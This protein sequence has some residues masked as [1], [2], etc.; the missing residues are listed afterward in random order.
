MR[1]CTSSFVYEFDFLVVID[2]DVEQ[3]KNIGQ[4][5]K[6]RL[7]FQQGFIDKDDLSVPY[8]MR[9][10]LQFGK[11]FLAI[12]YADFSV[13]QH[14]ESIVTSWR[15]GLPEKKIGKVYQFIMRNEGQFTD[16]VSTLS[17]ISSYVG[18][19]IYIMNSGVVG[20]HQ[21]AAIAL[22]LALASGLRSVTGIA[23]EMVF[24]TLKQF[25]PGPTIVLTKGDKDKI[26]DIGSRLSKARKMLAFII[27]EIAIAF[28]VGLSSAWFYERLFS[29]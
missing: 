17:S 4:R 8:F 16:I 11:I 6:L 10:F 21:L 13:A 20:F 26:S 29:K 27:V 1:E 19:S 5:Y 15:K 24:S 7:I 2:S 25:M 22:A 12:D 14:L 23:T 28:I 18:A 3:A 9:G